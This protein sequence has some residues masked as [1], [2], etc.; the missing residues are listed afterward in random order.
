MRC[1]DESVLIDREHL[2]VREETQREL[3]ERRN[4]PAQDKGSR[5][6]APK[7]N[8]RVLFVRS[9]RGFTRLAAG[10][11]E[12]AEKQVI[13]IVKRSGPGVPVEICFGIELES[14][15][16]HSEAA[17][18]IASGP[19]AVSAN[20]LAPLPNVGHAVLA[21]IENDIPVLLLEN[22]SHE[23]IGLFETFDAGS[24][25]LIAAPVV[26]QKIVAPVRKSLRVDRLMAVGAFEAG[27]S[28]WSRR[29]I[30]SRF[31]TF[32]VDI[33]C[34]RLHVG[35]LAARNKAP[36]GIPRRSADLLIRAPG[37]ASPT[38]VD[39]DVLVA[40]L[41]HPI[42]DHRVGRLPHDLVVNV[43]EPDIPAV[44]S[45]LRGKG[46]LVA[47]LDSKDLLCR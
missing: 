11:G 13:R 38:V 43:A 26:F 14:I 37:N 36:I 10:T 6:E 39:V 27:T 45:H 42:R 31:E 30:N 24:F 17:A 22:G 12:V 35:K 32:G 8:L 15:L 25:G 46:D 9:E 40:V 44:P 33:V 29:S 19:P 18:Q 23:A 7:R 20:L 21:E 28:C 47:A 34:Q 2:I 4:V 41:N 1:L 16:E 3:V 5:Y